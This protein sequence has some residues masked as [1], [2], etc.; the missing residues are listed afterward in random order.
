[1]SDLDV[2]QNHDPILN[3]ALKLV[4]LA[5]IPTII[6]VLILPENL[7]LLVLLY[8]AVIIFLF[9]KASYNETYYECPKCKALFKP[10]FTDHVLAPHQTYLKLLKCPKCGKISWCPLKIF[11][12]KDVR[13]KVKPPEEKLDANLERCLKIFTFFYIISLMPSI[14]KLNW[15][16]LIPSTVI[17]IIVFAELKNAIKKGYRT[18]VLQA[19][20]YFLIIPLMLFFFLGFVVE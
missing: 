7:K 19:L 18:H 16:P 11:M 6:V 20:T 15:F 17:Y 3:F 14:L 12:G 5:V 1:M 2:A 8:I 9:V 4:I 10:D 13:V